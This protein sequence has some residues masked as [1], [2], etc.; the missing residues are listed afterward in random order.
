MTTFSKFVV[1][2]A[3]ST[4]TVGGWMMAFWD[5]GGGYASLEDYAYLRTASAERRA[6]AGTLIPTG[7]DYTWLE[8]TNGTAAASLATPWTNLVLH[9]PRLHPSNSPQFQQTL[10]SDA[11][12]AR[13][14]MWIVPGVW[15]EDGASLDLGADIWGRH[16]YSVGGITNFPAASSW[17]SKYLDAS[18]PRAA[19]NTYPRMQYRMYPAVGLSMA[20]SLPSP[21]VR[22]LYSSDVYNSGY[23]ADDSYSRAQVETAV[24]T[25]WASVRP[26]DNAFFPGAYTNNRSLYMEAKIEYSY[27]TD[28]SGHYLFAGVGYERTWPLDATVY[29]RLPIPPRFYV[30]E[31]DACI[32]SNAWLVMV[33]KAVNQ[34]I[35]GYPLSGDDEAVGD[36]EIFGDWAQ[37]YG[38]AIFGSPACSIYLSYFPLAGTNSALR[39]YLVPLAPPTGTN[40]LYTYTPPAAPSL[41]SIQPE[42][43]GVYPRERP[44]AYITITWTCVPAGILVQGQFETYSARGDTWADVL[45]IAPEAP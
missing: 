38:N 32:V 20:E 19:S 43:F 34:F 37:W 45:Y 16:A 39:A 11:A 24:D 41:P 29:F 27:D 30:P 26:Y 8:L 1:I 17:F 42:V 25:A 13:D 9:L 4:A 31:S 18:I 35:T 12:L 23:N 5:R 36:G 22:T 3:A 44:G 6:L 21:H 40:T 2:A 14:G 28:G 10:L 15:P 7:E 33:P